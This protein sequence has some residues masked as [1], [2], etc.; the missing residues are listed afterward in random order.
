V[1]NAGID[2]NTSRLDLRLMCNHVGRR[3]T[4]TTLSTVMMVVMMVVMTMTIMMS[5]DRDE[6]VV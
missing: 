5:C 3:I 6:F 4:V 1:C 2:G